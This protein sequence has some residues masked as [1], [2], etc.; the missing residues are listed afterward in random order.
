MACYNVIMKT[1]QWAWPDD[2]I[3]RER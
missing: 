3:R 1:S 2:V